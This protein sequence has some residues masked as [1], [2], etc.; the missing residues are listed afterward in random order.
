MC[1]RKYRL[2]RNVF[3]AFTPRFDHVYKKVNA[4][5]KC[6]RLVQYAYALHV[7]SGRYCINRA[8][9]NNSYSHA[10]KSR[11]PG[12]H[13]PLANNASM[14]IF[15]LTTYKWLQGLLNRQTLSYWS[16][17]KIE[18]FTFRMAQVEVCSFGCIHHR[19]TSNCNKSIKLMFPHKGYGFFKTMVE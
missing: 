4:F 2:P 17:N 6:I 18:K 1:S 10:H 3:Y 8:M 14:H 11:S 16:I 7:V 19:S 9:R 15:R 5:T 13:P 12:R